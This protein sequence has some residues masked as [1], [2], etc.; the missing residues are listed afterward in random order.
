MFKCP[1][2]NQ[3]RDLHRETKPLRSYIRFFHASPGA[4]AVDVYIN[5]KLAVRNLI[6]KQFS[7][8]V[9]LIPGAYNIKLYVS[10]SK[11]NPI[12]NK[13]IMIPEQIIYTIGVINNIG[14]VDLFLINDPKSEIDNTKTMIR[15]VNLSQDS[16][17][18]D[19]KL[20]DGTVLFNNMQFKKIPGYKAVSP[21][22]Y[23][24]EVYDTGTNK[25]VLIIPNMVLKPDR[26]IT[27]YII[28]LASGKPNLE[29]V[30]PLDGN[31]YLPA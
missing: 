27:I 1:F 17:S 28:G 22:R 5:D 4:P 29:A 15:F 26:F 23:T 12:I 2:V 8:Y 24:F 3:F 10:G 25:R 7:S 21:G 31:T 14:N 20:S 18:L 13:N 19:L 9:P 11:E 30:L 16:S 6:F